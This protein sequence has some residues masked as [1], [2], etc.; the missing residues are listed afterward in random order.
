[1]LAKRG[2]SISYDHVR[3]LSTALINSVITLWEQI[4]EVVP[5]QAIREKLTTRVID[6]VDYNFLSTAA[7]PD[8]VL[9][10]TS[11]SCISIN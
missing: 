8:S 3:R 1:M 11:S 9:H 7:A 6:K 4:V 2:L 5:I 10:G